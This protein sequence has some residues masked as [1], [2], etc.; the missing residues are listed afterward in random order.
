MEEL[1]SRLEHV[2]YLNYFKLVNKTTKGTEFK[3][4]RN[5]EV[6]YL[7][8]NKTISIVLDPNTISEELRLKS[9][10]IYHSTVLKRFPKRLN[11]GESEITY[12]YSFKF[13]TERELNDF[14]NRYG[15]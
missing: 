6:V 5:G 7:I 15:R 13:D 8:P 9:D 1:M 2:F 3:G 12:G 11:T 10:G 4:E 14:L